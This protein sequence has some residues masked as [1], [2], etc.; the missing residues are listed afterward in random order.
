V[1]VERPRFRRC[2][3]LKTGVVGMIQSRLT[4]GLWLRSFQLGRLTGRKRL[5]STPAVSRCRSCHSS[6]LRL[7]SGSSILVR[8]EKIMNSVP[9]EVIRLWAEKHGSQALGLFLTPSVVV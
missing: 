1:G 6:T 2:W 9:I 7:Q 3:L 8:Q 4:R 5:S